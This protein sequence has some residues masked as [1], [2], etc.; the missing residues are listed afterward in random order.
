MMPSKSTVAFSLVFLSLFGARSSAQES[1]PIAKRSLDKGGYNNVASSNGKYDFA[2]LSSNNTCLT[3]LGNGSWTFTQQPTLQTGPQGTLYA[4]HSVVVGDFNGDNKPDLS[5]CDQGSNTISVYLG[6]GDGTFG[7]RATYLV[8][9]NP[10]AIALLDYNQDGQLDLA[11]ANEGSNNVSI[12]RGN[13]LGGFTL[14]QTISVGASPMG[15]AAGDLNRDGYVDIVTANWDGR[16]ISILYGS[17]SKAF[18]TAH[19]SLYGAA[20]GR[21]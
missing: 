13:G 6:K 19:R 1:R 15:I 2:A 11:V 14:A 16:N 5:M 3:Y 7:T 18:S 4:D 9:T 10:L 17:S 12:V 20:D 21:N 8:G